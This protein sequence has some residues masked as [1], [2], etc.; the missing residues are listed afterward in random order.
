MISKQEIKFVRSLSQ[1]K[2]REENSMFIIEGEKLLLEAEKSGATVLKIYKK[3]EI[4][5]DNMS[6][7]SLLSSS[8][9]VLAV[10]KMPE[11]VICKVNPM[12]LYLALDSVKDPGNLGTIIRIADWYGIDDIFLSEECVEV[13]NPKC[14]QATMGAIFRVRVHYVDLKHFIISNRDSLPVYGTFLEAPSIYNSNIQKRGLIVLGSESDGISSE[15]SS[16]IE[17]KIKI[18]P[19]PEISERSESLNVAVATAVVCSEFRR[20]S[21]S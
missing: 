21:A 5:D 1:K 18:P 12:N 11:R 9:P 2:F 19:F 10:I 13:Y 20:P 4:G 17:N 3:D 16:V 6:R 8:S 7:I 15:V 14:V